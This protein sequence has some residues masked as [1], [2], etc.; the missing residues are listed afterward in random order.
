MLNAVYRYYYYSTGMYCTLTVLSNNQQNQQ[1]QSVDDRRS[2]DIIL[3]FQLI[4]SLSPIMEEGSRTVAWPHTLEIKPLDEV[5]H[6]TDGPEAEA[7]AETEADSITFNILSFNVLAES[8]L[9]PRSHKNLP[10][11]SSEVVFNKE[12]RRNLL[13]HT[14]EKLA[15]S[16]D[17]IC[18]QEVDDYLREVIV[19]SLAALGYSF[20]YAPRGGIPLASS[21]VPRGRDISSMSV[22]VD[23]RSD[24]C[25][26]FFSK[27][28]WKC[29][30]YSVVNFDDL[31]EDERLPLHEHTSTI[32]DDSTPM[33][34]S[35]ISQ[36]K[37]KQKKQTALSGI[38]ASYKRRNAALLLELEQI[39]SP[40][41]ARRIVVANA[42][43]YW[44]PGYEYV[45]LSQAHYLL[46][47]V[48]QFV[49]KSVEE[50]TLRQD[51]YEVKD[52]EPTVIVCGDMNSKPNSV[53]H[54][55]FTKGNVDART[56]APWHFHYDEIDEQEELAL[57]MH[58]MTFTSDGD[59]KETDLDQD[60]V[61]GIDKDDSNRIMD[62]EDDDDNHIVA[63]HRKES[64]E[65]QTF[66]QSQTEL[67]AYETLSGEL[68]RVQP[69]RY[70][71]D[72]TLN[73]FTRWLRIL[74]QDAALETPEE[75]K[76]RTGDGD[77]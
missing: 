23:K 6:P 44:H 74:G 1:Q 57:Q 53:V 7:E 33:V 50:N 56:V 68:S 30:N 12:L 62:Q 8:Y 14:L 3:S 70:L 67:P 32:P 73:K 52:E 77:M 59:V 65:T 11:A 16:F 5:S 42:H 43:L 27:S 9:T 61:V 48:K 72:I 34:G 40:S 25:A 4:S 71:L 75:E 21:D 51:E 10:P 69:V 2:T 46:H 31:A 47:K 54:T 41:K 76:L 58:S 22:Q 36:K 45:K 18:L 24:G 26:T 29:V 28:K 13:K 55:Y 37:N 60:P 38:I 39:Q 66:L 35:N 17:I 20:V 63:A 15:N 64:T 49:A 19:E